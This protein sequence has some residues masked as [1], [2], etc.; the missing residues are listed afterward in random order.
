MVAL[1][2]LADEAFD[3]REFRA[4]PANGSVDVA[5]LLSAPAN[6]S[7]HRPDRL[8]GPANCLLQPP[9]VLSASVPPPDNQDQASTWMDAPGNHAPG[10]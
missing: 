6:G 7:Y 3:W 5:M 4:T 10:G 1:A 9:A 8:A 2:G